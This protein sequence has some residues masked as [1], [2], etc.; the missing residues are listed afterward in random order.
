MAKDISICVGTVGQ[1]IWQSPDGGENWAMVRQPFQLEAQVRALTPH[2]TQPKV[3][4]A[5]ANTGVYVSEDKGVSWERLESPM[6]DLHV[7]SLAI[8]PQDP[9]TIYAGT[10]PP[11]VFRTKDGGKNWEKLPVEMTMEC[12]IGTPRITALVVDP[13]NT[14]NVWAG[15]EIDGVYR[16][17]DGGDSWTKVEDG[18]GDPD[19]H[20]IAVSP[21]TPGNPGN[22]LVSTPREVFASNDTGESWRSLV[23]TQDFPLSYCRWVAVK[24]GEPNVVFA[25]N[26][27]G[28]YGS[29]GGIQKST[30]GGETWNNMP[31]PVE[32]NSS[33]WDFAFHP[34]DPDTILANT[35]YGELYTSGDGGDSWDKIKREFGEVRAVAWLPN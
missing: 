24:P 12:A 6:N 11:Y 32:P 35:L 30:D 26:G 25:A 16:S 1:G 19:I 34:S 22:V 23:K 18:V 31:L 15:V 27:S 9:D 3:I 2:P 17:L 28:A 7:W 29:T 20:G 33:I 10:R 4:Y 5:G 13:V 21:G 14:K 8:D